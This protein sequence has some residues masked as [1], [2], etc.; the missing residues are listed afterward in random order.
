MQFSTKLQFFCNFLVL[1]IET[2]GEQK[3]DFL[4]RQTTGGAFGE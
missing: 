2:P 3:P 1:E 4:I